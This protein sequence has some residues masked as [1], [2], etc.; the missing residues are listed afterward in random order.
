MDESLCNPF[1]KDGKMGI[2]PLIGL[3]PVL[4]DVVSLFVSLAFVCR[5]APAL[6]R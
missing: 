4:G 1:Q 6:N 3:V 2:D 5:A